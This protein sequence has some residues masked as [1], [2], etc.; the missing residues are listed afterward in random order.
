MTIKNKLSL[1]VQYAYE[2]LKDILP[3]P[4]LRRWVQAALQS[5]AQ[6]TLRFVDAA[7]GRELNRDYRGKDYA[8][9]VLTFDYDNELVIADIIL[10]SDVLLAEAAEQQKTVEAH[11]AHLIVHGVLHAQGYEHEDDDEAAEM[12]TLEAGILAKLGFPNPYQ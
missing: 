3:R 4:L 9:N 11:A 2:R 10:C 8:T 5:P 12:E 7:E 1:S 6:L